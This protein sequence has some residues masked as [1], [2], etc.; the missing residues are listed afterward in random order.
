MQKN[1]RKSLF[2]NP[3]WNDGCSQWSSMN[4]KSVKWK[5]DRELH[6][7]EIRLIAP[8]TIYENYHLENGDY[9]T[10]HALW[11]DETGSKSITCE[12]FFPK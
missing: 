1:D 7:E 4:D 3:Q 11:C 5:M 9:Q 12:V 6:K 2:Y 10:V 8:E